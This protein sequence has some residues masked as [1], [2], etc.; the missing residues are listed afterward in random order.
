MSFRI[1]E[2][3]P[4]YMGDYMFKEGV[5]LPAHELNNTLY[6][7]YNGSRV[8]SNDHMDIS[9]ILENQMKDFLLEVCYLI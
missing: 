4:V 5:T 8:V 7:N 2:A 1:F 3:V 6:N 9:V